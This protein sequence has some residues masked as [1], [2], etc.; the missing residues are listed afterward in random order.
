MHDV[1]CRVGIVIKN[2][3]IGTANYKFTAHAHIE[4]GRFELLPPLDATR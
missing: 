1:R 3:Q 2:E 4:C